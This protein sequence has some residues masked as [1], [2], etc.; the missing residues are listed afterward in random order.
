M[1]AAAL[2]RDLSGEV[3]G[4][5]SRNLLLNDWQDLIR[6]KG[7]G[8]ARPQPSP[9]TGLALGEATGTALGVKSRPTGALHLRLSDGCASQ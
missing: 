1:E 7:K 2:L 9:S 4:R 6:E 8:E 5:I 3:S